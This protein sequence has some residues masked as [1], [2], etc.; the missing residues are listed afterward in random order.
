M[1]DLVLYKYRFMFQRGRNT[2]TIVKINDSYRKNLT[3]FRDFETTLVCLIDTQTFYFRHEFRA[4]FPH[5]Q[6][7]KM[8]S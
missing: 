1:Y 7:E 4:F 3:L 6:M 8:H 2:L 5:K